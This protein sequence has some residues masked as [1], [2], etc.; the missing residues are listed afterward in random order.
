[1]AHSIMPP[2]R[3]WWVYLRHDE[4]KTEP[5]VT[6]ELLWRVW[7]Y[8][9]PYRFKVVGLLF[10]ILTITGL[11]LIP[12]LLYRNLI[13]Y[14]LPIGDVTRLNLLA[15][16]MIAIPLMNAAVGTAQRYLSATIGETL[17][18]DLRFELFSHL[19]RMSLRF[20]T[21][22]KT[23]ELMSR[24]N[25]D[26]I[27]AQSA[28]TGTFI[29]I[30][31]NIVTVISTLAIMV[32]LEWRLTLISIALVP[33]FVYPA[34]RVGNV[35]R[36][37]RR[38]SMT[39]NA[40]MSGVLNEALNVDGALLAKLF[41]R[42]DDERAKFHGQSHE[43]ARI[44]VRQAMIGRWFFM[45]LG[46]ISAV[47]TALVFWLGGH[48]V[49][50]GTFTIGTIVAFGSYLTQLYGPLSSMSN[51]H[52]EFA[53][54]LVSFERVFEVLDLP[55]EI[56]DQAAAVQL[57]E[58]SGAVSFHEVSFSYTAGGDG[59]AGLLGLAAGSADDD[60]AE[61]T[62]RPIS[63]RKMAVEGVEF[64]INPGQLV[65][66][67]G[68]SGAGKTTLTYLLPRLYDPTSGKICL[69]GQD[70]RHISLKS[71]AE[72][73]GMV[74]QQS[75]MFHDTVRA[76][77]LY[78]RPQAT[79]A[80]IEAACQAA[81]IHRFISM[82]PKQY[83]TV[84]GERGYRLSGGEKQRLAIARVILKDPRILVLDE[85]TSS[86]DSQSEV[87][88]QEALERIMEG[89]TSIVIAHRL[90]TI[91]AA[92]VILVMHQGRLAEQAH[93]NGSQSAHEQLLAQNGLYATL[94]R[95]QFRD[96]QYLEPMTLAK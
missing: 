27:G 74:T 57:N 40:K 73:I 80:E 10:T 22:I 43:V 16:A 84:V 35:L 42:Q 76:N 3:S 4:N 26:V 37:I 17:I 33:L 18:A 31:T 24:I 32:S 23:G 83:D 30:L 7:G 8:A 58:V 88:I 21:H 39:L 96:V 93:G 11:S 79:Q 15:L 77:L 90:S 62:V 5:K 28:L 25:N 89:R 6:L 49:L 69:D 13:D 81:N 70:L 50:Q 34:R 61:S 71:L 36:Q 60:E 54:S 29:N 86:L 55:L 51:A 52:I 85:A 38:E 78:A 67:V 44:G 9:Y 14:A 68:P 64:N 41:G 75:Y 63:T 94:Y 53:T 12:P 65:A 56:E 72:N 66:L 47:G 82:L 1:M 95:T 46:L 59:G 91:L 87:L 92:D 20:F 2:G 48:F 45:T 19:Q